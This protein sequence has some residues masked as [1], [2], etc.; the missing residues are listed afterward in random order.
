[1]R[2]LLCLVLLCSS[3]ICHAKRT[4]RHPVKTSVAVVAPAAWALW[5]IDSQTLMSDS[6]SEVIRPIASITKLMTVLVTMDMGLDMDETITITGTERSAKIRRGMTMKRGDVVKLA[7]IA[8]DNLAARTLSETSRLT[9][10]QYLVAMNNKAIS[11]GMTGTSYSDPTGLFAANTSRPSDLKLLIAETE[12]Y[13]V[14]KESAM[15]T[16]SRFTAWFKNRINTVTVNNTNSFAGHLDL[17][18]AKTGYTNPA[19][20]CLTMFFTGINGQ[21]YILVVLGAKSNDQRRKMV[22]QLIDTVS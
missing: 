14:F 9:Y 6:N 15:A 11:L 8:S 4:V 13:P 17:I 18:G 20:R 5:N 3:Q 16:S 2:L 12:R 7:L 10:D 21:R 19:G 22:K 1:M